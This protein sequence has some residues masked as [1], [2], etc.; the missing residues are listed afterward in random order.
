MFLERVTG[1]RKVNGIEIL[2]EPILGETLLV[3]AK[4]PYTL[5]YFWK[6]ANEFNYI[7]DPL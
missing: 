1:L 6:Y 7:F 5:M 2:L 4:M 3:A